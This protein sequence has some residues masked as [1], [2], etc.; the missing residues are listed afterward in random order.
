MHEDIVMTICK[1][2]TVNQKAMQG[3]EIKSELSTHT[4]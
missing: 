1:H 2:K 3:D 4:Q